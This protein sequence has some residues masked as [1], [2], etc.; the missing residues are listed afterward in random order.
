MSLQAAS[1][2]QFHAAK[3][4]PRVLTLNKHEYELSLVLSIGQIG[5]SP[6]S[7]VMDCKYNL[8][9]SS[10]IS[11]FKYHFNSSS[12]RLHKNN[13]VSSSVMKESYTCFIL[14]HSERAERRLKFN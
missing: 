9:T 3:I 1:N 13:S 10:G 14:R 8:K 5:V 11:D 2:P 12:S 6:E 7:K 4:R